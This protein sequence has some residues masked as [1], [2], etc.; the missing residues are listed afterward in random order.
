[1]GPVHLRQLCMTSH[2]NHA[3]SLNLHAR[4]FK[5]PPLVAV[6]WTPDYQPHH[7]LQHGGIVAEQLAAVDLQAQRPGG[8]LPD[9]GVMAM[10]HHK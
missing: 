10:V 3:G 6:V 9:T 4:G 5:V 1:M 2:T 7:E 8:S